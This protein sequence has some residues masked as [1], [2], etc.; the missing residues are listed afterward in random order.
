[1]TRVHV[2]VEG[3]TEESFV[4]EVLA[5]ELGWRGV[6]LTPCR[7]GTFGHRGGNVTYRRVE[8]HVVKLLRQD[9]GAY[10]TM[11]F[12]LYGLGDGF[13]ANT[14]VP[15][16][17]CRATQ[18]ER[19]LMA[20]IIAAHGDDLRADVRLIP[21][22]QKY[23]FEGL[24]FSDPEKLAHAISQPQLQSEFQSIRAKFKTPEEINDSPE[25]AP[26]KRI[27]RYCPSYQKP[28]DGVL[29]AKAIGLA[30]IRRECPRFNAWITRL[31]SL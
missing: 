2:I 28:Y 10:C 5:P 25:T 1:M 15:S 12:D 19:G 3:Q 16:D 29:A 24:L 26:S 22:F 31:E 17:A 21:Y 14:P 11:L 4:N 20:D 18:I 9:K 6:Y 8:S 27:L 30:I 7:L 23:E 13:S